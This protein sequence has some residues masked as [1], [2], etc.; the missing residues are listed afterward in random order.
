MLRTYLKL[1]IINCLIRQLPSILFMLWMIIV[2]ILK[3]FSKWFICTHFTWVITILQKEIV[4]SLL[5][6]FLPC[7]QV[8]VVFFFGFYFLFF[9]P[10]PHDVSISLCCVKCL[11][12]HLQAEWAALPF[13]I[14]SLLVV[15]RSFLILHV[16]VVLMFF[17]NVSPAQLYLGHLTY[18]YSI[19][20]WVL[21]YNYTY[22]ILI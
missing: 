10:F 5:L 7:Y 22:I 18:W 4:S 2:F 6:P 17:I 13:T 3:C 11:L 14:S 1:I 12:L 21:S 19:T 8:G 16:C 15:T 9:L 20:T